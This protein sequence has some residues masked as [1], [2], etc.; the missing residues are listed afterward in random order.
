MLLTGLLQHQSTEESE[1]WWEENQVNNRMSH[2]K[3]SAIPYLVQSLFVL[4]PIE[5]KKLM[6][7]LRNDK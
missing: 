1:L 5:Y 6:T 2:S 7:I 3:E 4:Y